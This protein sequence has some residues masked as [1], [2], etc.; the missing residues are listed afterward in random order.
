M[1]AIALIALTGCSAT[2]NQFAKNYF[3][4]EVLLDDFE[5]ALEINDDLCDPKMLGMLKNTLGD[6]WY[7]DRVQ[8]CNKENINIPLVIK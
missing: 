4:Q 2:L 7:N 5:R 1:L 8:K 3:E 6:E